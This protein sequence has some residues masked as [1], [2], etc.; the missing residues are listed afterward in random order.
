VTPY[1]YD[2]Q[3]A[4]YLGDCRE[5]LPTLW[6]FDACLTDPPYGLA[7]MGKGWDHA[8]PGV[9]YW[10]PLLQALKPGAP[11]L[12]FGGTRTHHRLACA[13]EDAG[14][15]LRDCLMW[16]YG[17]GFPKSLDLSKA[18]DKAA[19]AEREVI[20]IDPDRLARLKNQLHGSVSTGGEWEHGPRDVSITAP[21][22][23]A[24]KLWSGYGTALKPAWEP[25]L[26]AMKP[27]DGTFAENV[28]RHGVGG[29]NVDGGRIKAEAGDYDHPGN[30]DRRPMARNSFAAAE[31]GS[32]KA[33]QAAPNT[34]GRWPA[35][36]L[37]DGSEEVT[38]RF[39]QTA[40]GKAAPGGHVRNSDKTRTAYGAFEGQRCE[41]DVLYGD[42]GSSAARFFYCAKASRSERGEGNTH[43]TVKPLAL[44]EYLATLVR[45][46]TPGPLLVDPFMGSG[47]T[48]LAARSRGW[49][50]VGVEVSEEYCEIA[51][52]RLRRKE[53]A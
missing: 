22:T 17:S 37:H 6:P 29:L 39:P 32:L 36:V 27:L 11:L 28:Q 38:S 41:G 44:L 10:L 1:Y 52:N 18:I 46:P 26:L 21:A 31:Q 48:L 20:G 34:L 9:D 33:T 40:S 51:A 35:N 2:D 19:G 23:E 30:A 53:A 14:F 49:F 12:A 42:A 15:E 47:S 24:A 8:V 43:P 50:S 4:I 13:I 5:V 45:P 16:L 7:F 25:I 3:C